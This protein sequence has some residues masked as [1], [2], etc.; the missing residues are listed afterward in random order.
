MYSNIP[1]EL[2]GLRQWVTANIH[3]EPL[4]PRTGEFA[5][6]QDPSTWG[7]F[8]EAVENRC[9]HIGFVFTKGDPYAIID[10]DD[11]LDKPATEQ[12]KER[13]AKILQHFPSYSEIS[14]SGR[15]VHIV[16]RGAVPAGTKRDNVELYSDARMMIFTGNVLRNE[17]IRDHNDLLQLLFQEMQGSGIVTAKELVPGSP[18]PYKDDELIG[19][20]CTAANGD[21]FK[22][23][24]RGEW[25]N[26][27]PSQS[28]ADYALLSILAFYSPDNEQIM[29]IFRMTALGQRSKATRNDVYLTRSINRIRAHEVPAVDMSMLR[30]PSAPPPIPVQ[31]D[32]YDIKPYTFP[33]G[34]IGATAEW[35]LSFAIRPVR[36]VALASALALFS[37]IVGRSFNVS[38]TG[39]NQ[40]LAVIALTG[41]GKEAGNE[42]INRIFASVRQRVPS[43]EQFLGPGKFASGQGLVRTLDDKQCFISVLGEFGHHIHSWSQPGQAS[44]VTDIRRVLLDVYSKSGA[45]QMLHPSAYS[46]KEKNTKV[47]QSPCI[48]ILGEA[49]PESFYD[50]LSIDQV[51]EGL[52]PR[53]S[54]IE[55]RGDR[56]ERNRARQLDPPDSLVAVISDLATIA[57]YTVANRT[58]CQVPISAEALP[59]LDK[60]DALADARI[61]RHNEVERQLWNRAHLKALKLSALI[62][63]CNNPHAPIIGVEEATWA[64]DF[65]RHEIE[66]MVERFKNQEYGT[67][68]TRYE[69]Y[70]REIVDDYFSLDDHARLSTYRVPQ[71]LLGKDVVPYCYLRRRMKRVSAF[72]KDRRGATLA[73]KLCLQDLCEAGVL[74]QLAPMQ[75]QTMFGT[76]SAVY[77]RGPSW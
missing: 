24:C 16:V 75:A 70:V 7:T 27:Y 55:Y 77:L 1:E 13:F 40:Y 19:I 38:G 3:K 33:P 50:N 58:T 47:I 5:S 31:E 63:A 18:S 29:R 28:E 30:I 10:L 25:Q 6:V 57:L 67:G 61:R 8:E 71:S 35:M 34:V 76:M 14:Q 22:K 32:H 65:V 44:A 9:P 59:L 37:G 15:G 42:A 21:K 49:T 73:I 48:T 2:R 74:A 54:V 4:N 12:Q 36:E 41:T 46:D 43:V 39:L 60:F 66:E 64:I 51:A 26:E 45:N 56:P 68:E 23:L 11:K 52:I 20:A 72:S 69:G 17:P 62:S 53:F